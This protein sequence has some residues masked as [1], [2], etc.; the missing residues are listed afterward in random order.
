[1]MI[2]VH[3]LN[4]RLVFKLLQDTFKQYI[5]FKLIKKKND[6]NKKLFKFLTKK[7]S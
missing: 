7:N 6:K 5:S 4:I 1:M 3:F 2:C